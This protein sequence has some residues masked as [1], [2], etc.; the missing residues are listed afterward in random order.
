[1]VFVVSILVM[2]A[3]NMDFMTAMGAVATSLN[4][5]GPGVGAVGPAN[6][7]SQVHDGAKVFLA[8]LMLLGRLELFTVLI[9]FTPYLWKRY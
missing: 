1:V 9:L 6:S 7:F 2:T 3:L 8:F 5:V 4:N